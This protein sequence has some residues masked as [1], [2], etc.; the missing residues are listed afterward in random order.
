MTQHGDRSSHGAPKEVSP[1]EAY[2]ALKSGAHALLL[3]VRSA[4]EWTFVG[5]PVGP[6]G[7]LS[8]EWQS[9]PG[10]GLN[11]DFLKQATAAIAAAGGDKTTPVFVI[12]RSGGRSRSAASALI[13]AGYQ[14][15][16]V[17]EGFEGDL[18]PSSGRR[19]QFNGWRHAGLPW[20]QS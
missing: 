10:M 3:D 16:N 14:A 7:I 9:Y 19:S 17:A 1:A 11:P 2:D 15:I 20:R 4:A 5:Q 8:V 12:C 13:A 6:R 18:D